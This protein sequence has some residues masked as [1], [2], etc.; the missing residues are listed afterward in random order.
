M[1]NGMF[2]IYQL[3]KDFFHPQYHMIILDTICLPMLSMDII[4]IS[5]G[6]IKWDICPQDGIQHMI[7]GIYPQ[8][9]NRGW[10]KKTTQITVFSWV[11]HR[12]KWWILQPWLMTKG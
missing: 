10:L 8:V 1:N 2:T 5:Y 3:M 7:L 6:I 4:G 12:T 9:I 11:R